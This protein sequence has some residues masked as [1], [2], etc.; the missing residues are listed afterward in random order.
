MASAVTTLW[1]NFFR[2]CDLPQSVSKAYAAAFVKERIQPYLLKELG[3]DELRE[4]GVQALGDQLAIMRYV[5]KTG[6]NPPEFTSSSKPRSETSNNDMDMQLDEDDGDLDDDVEIISSSS[7]APDRREIY[8]I[9]MPEGRTPKTREIL[10]KHAA[11]RE[12]GVIKRGT[13]GVRISGIDVTKPPQ[14]KLSQQS[15]A[16]RKKPV[17]IDDVSST[18]KMRSDMIIAQAAAEA[19]ESTAVGSRF[20]QRAFAAAPQ[21]KM[22]PVNTEFRINLNLDEPP[23]KVVQARQIRQAPVQA[24]QLDKR[25]TITRV[26]RTPIT[27]RV[28][29]AGARAAVGPQRLDGRAVVAR[30]RIQ[31]RVTIRAAAPSIME[32]VRLSGAGPRRGGVSGAGPRRGAVAG[33]GPRRG[34]MARKAFLDR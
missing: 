14:L 12:Q 6:G 30:P 4:L 2:A 34:G 22:P 27:Q 1:E 33:A 15:K 24:R 7:K 31:D 23:S 3:K 21:R 19:A 32:R 16:I 10:Q 18:S 20:A 9:R 28:Q 8:H 11:L 13:S 26:I 17:M 29:L 5:K 25:T